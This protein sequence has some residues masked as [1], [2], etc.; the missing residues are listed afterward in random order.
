M[1][2]PIIN[3]ILTHTRAHFPEEACGLVGIRKGKVKF[4]P[5]ENRS[6]EPLHDF[7]IDP[8]EYRKVSKKADII[9]VIHNHPQG[10]STP[11]GL[12]RAVCNKLGIPWYI[13]DKDEGY[14]KIEPEHNGK[15]DLI[16]REFVFG[17]YDCF[18]II[19]DYYANLGIKITAVPYDWKFWE[20]GHNL[21]IDNYEKEGFTKIT[22]NSLQVHDVILMAVGSNISNHAG[23]YVGDFKL[24]H[25]APGRL[26]CRDNYNGIWKQQK[27]AI[28]RHEKF[29]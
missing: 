20:K 26:S 21:Y 5:C 18:T 27:R 24:L 7:I 6:M 13:F 4:Y 29:L 11:S 25:H 28:L 8:G 9:G 23:I 3:N 10:T 17:A 19:Q 2:E 16:G 1:I 14:S 12:D 15:L 22:D